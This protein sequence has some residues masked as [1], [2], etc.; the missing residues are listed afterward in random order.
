MNFIGTCSVIVP[1]TNEFVANTKLGNDNLFKFFGFTS[2]RHY[3]HENIA[4]NMKH[5][6]L[7]HLNT[8]CMSSNMV[9]IFLPPIAPSK[10]HHIPNK[11]QIT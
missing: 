11:V 4:F 1:N 8:D 3:L 2:L 9:E 5:E 10:T 6:K 7:A